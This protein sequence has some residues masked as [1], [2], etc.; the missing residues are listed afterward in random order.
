M[1]LPFRIAEASVVN[2]KEQHI[3]NLGRCSIVIWMSLSFRIAE[4][5]LVNHKEHLDPDSPQ[6]TFRN[7]ICVAR[8]AAYVCS[9]Q[10]LRHQ[11]MGDIAPNKRYRLSPIQ[12]P[13]S[14]RLLGHQYNLFVVSCYIYIE[15]QDFKTICSKYWSENSLLFIAK[16]SEV[17]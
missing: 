13:T 11:S 7:V 6:M 5:S 8:S 17:N 2:H 4:A 1:S 10:R 9:I 15:N 14:H 3:I 16:D 12:L